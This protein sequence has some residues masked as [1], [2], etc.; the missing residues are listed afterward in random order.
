M[1]LWSVGCFAVFT[2][3]DDRPR[4]TDAARMPAHVVPLARC[5]VRAVTASPSS[6]LASSSRGQTHFLSIGARPH[7]TRKQSVCTAAAPSSTAVEEQAPAAML[8][9]AKA[10]E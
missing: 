8:E 4:Q 9:T 10:C 7:A 5:I 6:S 2:G 1:V 3:T